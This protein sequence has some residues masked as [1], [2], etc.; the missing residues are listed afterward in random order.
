M[1]RARARAGVAVAI[2]DAV[3]PPEPDLVL[4][5]GAAIGGLAQVRAP[6]Q[7]PLARAW[8]TRA[9]AQVSPQVQAA[10]A[11]TTSGAARPLQPRPVLAAI[12]VIEAS[13]QIQAPQ[14]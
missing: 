2:P 5:A 11:V 8:A 7:G 10:V 14:W 6:Q 1:S 9:R 3:K 13:A 12:V 4:I